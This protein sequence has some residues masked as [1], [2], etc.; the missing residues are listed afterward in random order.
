MEEPAVNALDELEVPLAESRW[1]LHRYL[2]SGKLETAALER[3]ILET[4]S[5]A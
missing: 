1:A 2:L 5:S 4:F 3:P